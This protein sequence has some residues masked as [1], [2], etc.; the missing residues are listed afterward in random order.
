MDSFAEP[1]SEK[2]PKNLEIK[3]PLFTEKTES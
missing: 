3:F 2:Y 1:Y